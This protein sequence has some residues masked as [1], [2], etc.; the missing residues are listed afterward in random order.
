MTTAILTRKD[1]VGVTPFDSIAWAFEVHLKEKDT[2]EFNY[3]VLFGNEDCPDEIV[4]Y[5]ETNPNWNSPDG[6]VWKSSHLTKPM[7]TQTN[8]KKAR[9]P[10][11]ACMECGKK[12]YS[13]AAAERAAFGDNGCPSCGGSDIDIYLE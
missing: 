5:R 13:A 8:D 2:G 4:F 10:L 6:R 12:F 3:A 7:T 9:K 11:F 1:H